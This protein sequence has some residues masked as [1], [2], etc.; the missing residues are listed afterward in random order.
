M[1]VVCM[2]LHEQA[3]DKC[4][5]LWWLS[6]LLSYFLSDLTNKTHLVQ[7][8]LILPGGA[9]HDGCQEGLWI[10]EPGKPYRVRKVEI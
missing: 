7:R 9:L 3:M 2:N 6:N 5:F 8:K 1:E 4:S 10:E